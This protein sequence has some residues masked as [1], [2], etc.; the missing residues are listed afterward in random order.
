MQQ[1][2][3]VREACVFHQLR[4]VIP[5][6]PDRR[7]VGSHNRGSP[8]SHNVKRTALCSRGRHECCAPIASRRAA[9]PHSQNAYLSANCMMRAVDELPGDVLCACGEM[10]PNVELF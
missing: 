7:L 3:R 2:D 6:Y 9:S 1:E 10:Y 8:V 5:A 4:D